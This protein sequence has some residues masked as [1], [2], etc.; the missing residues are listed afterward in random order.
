ME[1]FKQGSNKIPVLIVKNH[2]DAIIPERK[3]LGS[4]GYDLYSVEEETII[5]AGHIKWFNIGLSFSIPVG[6]YG[7]I[8]ER[9]SLSENYIG[10]KAG[11]IDSD[12]RGPVKVLLSNNH[13][14]I[15]TAC[16]IH[17]GERIAQLIILK[18]ENCLFEVKTGELDKTARGSNGFG[19]TG[20]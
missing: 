19:S 5:N 3:T 13:H 8:E 15:N 20:K 9:S 17:K 12:Y 14:D 6:Y 7:K 4:A 11:I 10:I 18:C 2:Q 16:I 1:S